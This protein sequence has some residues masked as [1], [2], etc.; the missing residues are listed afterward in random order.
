MLFIRHRINT[1][2][3]L[4]AVPPGMGVELDLR[5]EGKRLILHHD[6]FQPGETFE[7]YLKAYHHGL[8]IVNVKAEGLE[9][10]ALELLEKYGVKNYFFLDLSFP[11]LI[12]LATRGEPNIAVRFSEFEPLEQCLA[13]KG[14]VRW[15]WVDC[16]TNLPLTR[17]AYEK[18]APHFKI[19]LVSPELQKHSLDRIAEFRHQLDGMKIDAVCTK[20]PDLWQA[21]R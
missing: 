15:V 11:A 14:L 5:S 12:K 17:V 13:L 1:A 21:A 3:E 16:F 6:P 19:C 9:E 10:P 20:R 4:A 2:A 8:M 7:D 18:L